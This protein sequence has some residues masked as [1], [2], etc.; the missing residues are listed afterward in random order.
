MKEEA[1]GDM[2]EGEGGGDSS[3]AAISIVPAKPV[4]IAAH[5]SDAAAA[6]A[7]SSL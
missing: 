7:P 2:R 1:V 6:A 4:K 3:S 5:P